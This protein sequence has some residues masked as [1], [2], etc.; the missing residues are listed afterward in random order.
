MVPEVTY[1]DDS[2]PTGWPRRGAIIIYLCSHLQDTSKVKLQA[3]TAT[4]SRSG[5]LAHMLI[6]RRLIYFCHSRRRRIGYGGIDEVFW[7]GSPDV[8]MHALERC[9]PSLVSFRDCDLDLPR[10]GLPGV[11]IRSTHSLAAAPSL[12]ACSSG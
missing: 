2:C 8:G 11:N 3:S 12:H 10:Y 7:Q 5:Q 1:I 6:M 4:D 9:A